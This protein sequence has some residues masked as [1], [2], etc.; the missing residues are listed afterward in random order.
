MNKKPPNN[1]F[2]IDNKY[3]CEVLENYLLLITVN[4]N[5]HSKFRIY[6]NKKAYYIRKLNK[7][8]LKISANYD[9]SIIDCYESNIQDSEIKIINNNKLVKKGILI[10]KNSQ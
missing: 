2:Y 5:I 8:E 9:S 1:C 6:H 4:Y 7:Q 3:I 10:F